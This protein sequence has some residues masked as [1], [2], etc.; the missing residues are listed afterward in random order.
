M[1]IVSSMGSLEKLRK[2]PVSVP[3]LPCRCQAQAG[4]WS[5]SP[6]PHSMRSPSISVQPQP[7]TTKSIASQEWRWTVEV[8]PGS[9]SWTRASM[10]RVGRSAS[11]PTYTPRRMPRAVS[12][13]STS[14]TRTT[15]LRYLRHSSRKSARRFFCTW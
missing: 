4:R 9:I 14:P 12:C 8:T 2:R 3:S 13:I 5:E 11:A 15:V 10:E 7:P 1:P 6:G